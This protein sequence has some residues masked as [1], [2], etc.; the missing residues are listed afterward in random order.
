MSN[1]PDEL[2][3][4]LRLITNQ[5]VSILSPP[6]REATVACIC[7]SPNLPDRSRDP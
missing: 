3:E 5:P 6:N 4:D 1:F 2:P 7:E